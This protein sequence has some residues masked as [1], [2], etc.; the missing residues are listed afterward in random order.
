MP[1]SR[2][3][4]TLANFLLVEVVALA[5]APTGKG[6]G[7]EV[8]EGEKAR[9]SC[10][11]VSSLRERQE[12]ELGEKEAALEERQGMLPQLLSWERCGPPAASLLLLLLLPC[13]AVADSLG[14]R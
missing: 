5:A 8:E 4:A 14:K 3:L 2:G 6:E 1:L 7:K 12:E 11:V 13:C 10:C 9:E